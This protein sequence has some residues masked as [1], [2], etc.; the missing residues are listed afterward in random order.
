MPQYLSIN[1]YTT[2]MT[3]IP[4]YAFLCNNFFTQEK[5]RKV[6]WQDCS[7]CTITYILQE[8]NLQTLP[9]LLP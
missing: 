5:K 3:S 7:N 2:E 9:S 8:L 4:M 1:V 6:E